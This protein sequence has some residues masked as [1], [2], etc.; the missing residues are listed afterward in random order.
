MIMGYGESTRARAAARPS[1][2]AAG[3]AA[4]TQPRLGALPEAGRARK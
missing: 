3:S 1:A 2:S 4:E